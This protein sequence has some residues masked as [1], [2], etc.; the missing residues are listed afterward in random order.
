MTYVVSV[1]FLV[2]V[3]PQRQDARD[4]NDIVM[5]KIRGG[6]L[7]AAQYRVRPLTSAYMASL[8]KKALERI[9]K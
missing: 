3:D 4:A 9:N 8:E 7:L 2:E 1:D 6:G 5:A